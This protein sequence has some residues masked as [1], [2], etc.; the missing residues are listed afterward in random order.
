M[1]KVLILTVCLISSLGMSQQNSTW[2]GRVV[3]TNAP[4][5]LNT[6]VVVSTQKLS[7]PARLVALRIVW[8]NNLN[9]AM[10]IVTYL[11]GQTV[12]QYSNV[13]ASVGNICYNPTELWLDPKSLDTVVVTTQ[14]GQKTPSVVADF[15]R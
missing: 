1:R 6:N 3:G 4:A 15:T 14:A 12:Q 2:A 8:P 11:N 7:G 5:G 13:L 9:G 10:S